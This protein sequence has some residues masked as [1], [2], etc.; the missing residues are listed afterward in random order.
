VNP[1]RKVVYFFRKYPL[2]RFASVAFVVGIGILVSV[3]V[4]FQAKVIPI[5]ETIN[6][7]IA[8][9]GEILVIKGSGFGDDRETNTVTIGGGSITASRYL[10]WSDTEIRLMLPPNVADG[11]VVVETGAGK[12][13]PKI[14][15]NAANVPVV[16]RPDS[17]TNLPSVK[18]IAALSVYPGALVTLTGANFGSMR[19]ESSVLFTP[20]YSKATEIQIEYLMPSTRDY[21][22][23][24]WSDSEIRVRVPDGAASG[25]VSVKT[26]KGMSN[27]EKITVST[28]PVGIKRFDDGRVYVIHFNTDISNAVV[29]EPSS[30]ILRMPRPQ[31]SASQ[32]KV[33][34]QEC[35][36]E[37]VF[38]DFNNML[39]QQVQL[40]ELGGGKAFFTHSFVVPV[41][42]VT[43]EI[44]A[45]R[46]MPYTARALYEA[47]TAPD[48]LIKSDDPGIIALAGAIVK[49]ERNPYLQARLVYDYLLDSC[50]LLP[51]T[52]GG[53]NDPYDILADNRGD[54][55]D[56]AVLYC[57]LLRVLK[58]PAIPVAGIIVDS[59]KQA[60]PHWWCEFYVERFGWVPVDPSLGAGMQFSPFG[61]PPPDARGF[62]FG[63]MD[64]YHIAF[65]RGWK[66]VKPAIPN[67]KSVYH[68]RTY[69]FQSIWEEASAGAKQYSSFWSEPII[70]GIY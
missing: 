66:T 16:V 46:V 44:D 25:Q 6:P 27:A 33:D 60:H 64:A 62:Y 34:V 9:A 54:A 22:Y 53:E 65:S 45:V 39:I 10:S 1:G 19:G 59:E 67:S 63:N 21:D 20:A 31:V 12:S 7:P 5:I 14:L 32:P 3:T 37:P 41:Y 30:L 43:T 38:A 51:E 69:A 36:P 29:S 8:A 70:A 28:S 58:I 23:E 57:A 35:M 18:T 17:T 24:Y 56:F 48:E 50:A 42:G 52:R 15:A 11:L 4:S 26:D 68:P 55:Y 49:A 2:F 61:T 13:N 47:E 40:D